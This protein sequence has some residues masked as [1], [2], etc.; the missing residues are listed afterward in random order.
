MIS[1][2]ILRLTEGLFI[3]SLDMTQR[4]RAE[5]L[6]ASQL[7]RLAALRAIDL[8]ILGTTDWRVAI[9]TVLEETKARLAVDVAAILHLKMHGSL[10]LAASA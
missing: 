5:A 10:E 3:I 1:S 6:V 4:Q 2:G 7:Q 8:A 9:K